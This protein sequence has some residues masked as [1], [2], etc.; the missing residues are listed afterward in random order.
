MGADEFEKDWAADDEEEETEEDELK[1]AGMHVDGDD[2]ETPIE[3]DT[4]M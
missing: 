1:A 3:E 2:D 4:M